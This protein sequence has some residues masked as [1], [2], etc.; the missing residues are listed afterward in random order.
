MYIKFGIICFYQH[1]GGSELMFSIEM[2]IR[3]A[4]GYITSENWNNM[5]DPKVTWP[6]FM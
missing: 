6:E 5:Y 2:P 3:Q 4:Q 1:A